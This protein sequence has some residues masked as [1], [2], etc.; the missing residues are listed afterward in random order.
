MTKGTRSCGCLSDLVSSDSLNRFKND[1]EWA[2][3]DCVFYIAIYENEHIFKIGIS[4]NP[5]FRKYEGRY[6][7]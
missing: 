4:R 6:K 5:E 1:A 7:K 2:D 3:R